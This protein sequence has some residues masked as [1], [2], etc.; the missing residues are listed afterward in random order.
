MVISNLTS[1]STAGFDNW[2]DIISA[3]KW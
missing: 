3:A 1:T 2:D